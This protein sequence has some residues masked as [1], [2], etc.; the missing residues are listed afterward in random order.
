MSM[1]PISVAHC[2]TPMSSWKKV[3]SSASSSS[4]MSISGEL[5]LFIGVSMFECGSCL[6]VP[7]S[8]SSMCALDCCLY[9]IKTYDC[10]TFHPIQWLLLEFCAQVKVRWFDTI[11]FQLNVICT[12]S[13]IDSVS[14]EIARMSLTY[15]NM[16]S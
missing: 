11:V 2:S 13:S 6:R 8:A 14:Q 12:S 3:T 10:P 16:Y 4:V 9:I 7:L 5:L 15:I 1:R